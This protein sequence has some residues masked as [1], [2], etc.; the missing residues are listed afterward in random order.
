MPASTKRNSN[1]PP[2][3]VVGVPSL[4]AAVGRSRVA[5]EWQYAALSPKPRHAKPELV[6]NACDTVDATGL[7]YSTSISS[8]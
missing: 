7:T 1:S 8:L 6:S 4:Q 3:I 5:P 2:R